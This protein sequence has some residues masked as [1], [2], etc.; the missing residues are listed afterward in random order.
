M[1]LKTLLKNAFLTYILIALGK[2]MWA[3]GTGFVEGARTEFRRQR[4]SK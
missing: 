1:H 4:T 2:G 3:I